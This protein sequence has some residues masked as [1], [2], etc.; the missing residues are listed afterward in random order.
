M[1]KFLSLLFISG[2]VLA[3]AFTHAQL[4]SYPEGQPQQ[5]LVASEAEAV[6]SSEDAYRQSLLQIIKLLQ[7]QIAALLEKQAISVPD[8][9]D[10]TSFSTGVTFYENDDLQLQ[11]RQT[12]IR[13]YSYDGNDIDDDS[14]EFAMH[15]EITNKDNQEH[16]LIDR[17]S[18]VVEPVDSNR[19]AVTPKRTFNFKTGHTR[20]TADYGYDAND[21]KVLAIEPGQTSTVLLYH[22]YQF[23][24]PGTYR[25]LLNDVSYTL[26]SVEY[27][28][29]SDQF[30]QR[31]R[32]YALPSEEMMQNAP[33]SR[34][35]ILV[36]AT[37]VDESLTDDKYN[38]TEFS[39]S[40]VPFKFLYPE[41]FTIDETRDTW[42]ISHQGNPYIVV[43]LEDTLDLPDS[44]TEAE[45]SVQTL[46]YERTA[47]TTYRFNEDEASGT[48]HEYRSL[49]DQE[50]TILV[51]DYADTSESFTRYDVGEVFTST[52]VSVR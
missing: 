19:R 1:H 5:L 27:N 31:G 14:F 11:V 29:D 18:L 6:D 39:E 22:S 47:K 43:G 16:L 15:L 33:V 38:V 30:E 26:D 8:S 35:T 48:I 17:E 41:E 44:A 52:F 20:T 23:A 24:T 4:L 45:T 51:Y 28:S 34:I 46:N 7:M 49:R 9:G 36:D 3:P 21:R 40:K 12:A 13:P 37:F 25:G 2:L 32:V 10:S 42:T 50:Y